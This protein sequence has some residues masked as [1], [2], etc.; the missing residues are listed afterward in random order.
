LIAES[1]DQAESDCVFAHTLFVVFGGDVGGVE[2]SETKSC[3]VSLVTGVCV[4]GLVR[5][6]EET[7]PSALDG[8]PKNGGGIVAGQSQIVETL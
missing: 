1:A 8:L 2:W 4:K 6:R 7:G 3:Q 5:Q